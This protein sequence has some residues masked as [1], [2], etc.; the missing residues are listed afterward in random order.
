MLKITQ[1]LCDFKIIFKTHRYVGIHEICVGGKLLQIS[2]IFIVKILIKFWTK[3]L[4]ENLTKLWHRNFV[5]F[6]RKL[7]KIT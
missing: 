7:I 3:I 5:T 4:D 1:N 2:E 6:R